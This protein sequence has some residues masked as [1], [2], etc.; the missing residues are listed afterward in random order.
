MQPNMQSIQRYLQGLDANGL[1]ALA[2]ELGGQLGAGI[3]RN[4]GLII[5]SVPAD[6][7]GHCARPACYIKIDY[8]KGSWPY[9]DHDEYNHG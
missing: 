7:F 5:E 4:R 3:K 1:E 2:E 8:S 9:A 6:E